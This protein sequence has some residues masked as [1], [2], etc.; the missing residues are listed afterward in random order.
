[1]KI[2]AYRR[3]RKQE[4]G[5]TLIPIMIMLSLFLLGVLG[6]AMDYSQLWAHR[7]MAQAAADA[8]CQA[9]AADLYLFATDP[10]VS[11]TGGLTDFSFIGTNFDCSTK[12]GTPPC[13]YAAFNGYSGAN[14]SV[15]FPASLPG[16][17]ALPPSLATTF[18]YIK[19]TVKDAVPMSFTRLVSP[20]PTVT[21]TAT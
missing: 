11:S 12:P 15:S 10:S 6:V 20:N 14:V 16:V 13:Q 9:G 18:P 4:K 19:V 2:F 5:Q 7:Q 8:A 21:I 1:M 17:A 3:S